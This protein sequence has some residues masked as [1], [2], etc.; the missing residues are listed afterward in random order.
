MRTPL[1]SVGCKRTL[2][3][4]LG[5]FEEHKI[6]GA[7][8][9]GDDSVLQGVISQTSVNNYLSRL[10]GSLDDCV[11]EAM[12]PYA[13]TIFPHTPLLEV[14]ETLVSTGIHRIIVIDDTRKPI[15]IITSL[16]LVQDYLEFLSP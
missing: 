1:I 3:E 5:L 4:V 10:N 16:D 9:V 7:P 11:E 8:I 15:G 6:S 2:R 12:T 14:L 13:F